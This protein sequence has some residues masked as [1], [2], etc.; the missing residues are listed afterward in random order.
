MKKKISKENYKKKLEHCKY[1]GVEV[2]DKLKLCE[3]CLRKGYFG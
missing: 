1:C 3:A 2:K